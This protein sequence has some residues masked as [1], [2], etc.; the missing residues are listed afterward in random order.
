[1]VETEQDTNRPIEADE[2]DRLP[3]GLNLCSGRADSPDWKFDRRVA[4]IDD[5]QEASTR[6][7]D[8]PVLL[9]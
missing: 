5:R 3:S 2:G 6:V 8:I 4:V 1:M 9:D 7:N